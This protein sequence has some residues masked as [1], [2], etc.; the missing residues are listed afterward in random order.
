MTRWGA[1]SVAK[2][3]RKLVLDFHD[4]RPRWAVTDEAADRIRHCLPGDWRFQRLDS[5]VTS[6][7]DGGKWV[8]EEALDAVRDAEI[9][10]GPGFPRELLLAAREL[11]WVHTGAAGVGSLM[12]PE[13]ISA[14]VV[15]TNSAGVHAIPVAETVLAM[16]LH[17]ARGLDFAVRSQ[18]R[19]AW[20]QRP[21]EQVDSV[22][23]ELG[24][25]VLGIIGFGGI[26]RETAQR[27]GALGM[28]VLATRTD[29][30]PAI[31]AQ[32]DYV[33]I[34]VPS[35]PATRGMIGARQIA[36]M[37]P[38]AVLINVA[39]GDVIDQDALIGALRAGSIRG[40]GLDVFT[41]EP[42]PQDSELWRLDNVLILPH[43]S[44]TSPRFWE[45]EA[46]LIVDNIG[47][48]LRGERLRN[49]VD[50]KKGY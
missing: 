11:K 7:G 5:P 19:G 47:R 12:Y 25:S 15:L 42:L 20:D 9:Y 30:V 10:V 44:A 29:S 50:K 18:A 49:T 21:F 4:E 8:S 17:F 6:R 3:A 24:G 1:G 37:K 13:M 40:A 28:N 41:P 36:A 31:L 32:S 2:L 35:T 39:R 26:G 34:A 23:S 38:N 33:V 27:A 14:D 43:I 16:I 46:D 48:Y 22:I 45:R